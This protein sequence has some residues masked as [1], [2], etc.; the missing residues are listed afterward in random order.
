M[1]FML[2]FIH[3]TSIATRPFLGDWNVI[4]FSLVTVQNEREKQ[5]GKS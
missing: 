4:V 2:A 5:I 3:L 1:G